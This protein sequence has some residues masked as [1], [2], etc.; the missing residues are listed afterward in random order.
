MILKTPMDINPRSAGKTPALEKWSHPLMASSN[1]I[2]M[3]RPKATLVMQVSEALL[4][5][6]KE[7][8]LEF[9]TGT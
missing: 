5:N 4:G 3:E 1:A 7:N 8:L 6:L 2:L 9:I